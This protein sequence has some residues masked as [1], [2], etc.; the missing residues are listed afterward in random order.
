MW[1]Y[2]LEHKKPTND[3]MLKKKE[4]G[5]EEEEWLSI[6]QQLSTPDRA[7]VRDGTWRASPQSMKNLGCMR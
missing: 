4:K 6:L 5:G 2:P 3:Y 7:F 1:D